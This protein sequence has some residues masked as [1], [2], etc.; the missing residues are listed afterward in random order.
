MSKFNKIINAGKEIFQQSS[1]H[2]I[3]NIINNS[4]LV[5]KLIWL[6]SVLISTC[7]LIW[8]TCNTILDY[9]EYPVVSSIN[10][11]YESLTE[12]PTI[13]ICSKYWSDDFSNKTNRQNFSTISICN[14][15]WADS[16]Q[17]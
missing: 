5:T 15:Y 11:N 10:T 4:N 2:G 8:F 13:T 9:L 16:N 7:A 1:A 3:P 6:L 12:F 14:K 17:N